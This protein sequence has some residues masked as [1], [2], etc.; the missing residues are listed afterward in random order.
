MTLSHRRTA[1]LLAAGVAYA[2]VARG[3]VG[4]VVPGLLPGAGYNPLV[5]GDGAQASMYADVEFGLAAVLPGVAI[6]W[7]IVGVARRSPRAIRALGIAYLIDCAIYIGSV[8]F[9]PAATPAGVFSRF[10]IVA[11]LQAPLI[12]LAIYFATIREL[13][14]SSAGRTCHSH[15]RTW[16][17]S[18]SS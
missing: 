10:A 16:F 3:W 2:I 12:A 17:P 8:A 18:S 6:C 14:P 15:H 11:L 1:W 5:N 4:M 7:V 9:V 13:A